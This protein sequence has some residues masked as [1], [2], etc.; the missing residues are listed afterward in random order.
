ML[1]GAPTKLGNHD[2]SLEINGDSIRMRLPATVHAPIDA[3]T[4][5]GGCARQLPSAS[6]AQDAPTRGYHHGGHTIRL[7]A[8][9]GGI[10][11]EPLT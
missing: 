2:V 9:S 5:G 3:S 11:I 8:N 1:Q 7:H 4:L 10:S 6:R